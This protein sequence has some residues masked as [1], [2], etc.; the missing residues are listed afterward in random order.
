MFAPLKAYEVC[1]SCKR[2]SLNFEQGSSLWVYDDTIKPLIFQFKYKE[3]THLYDW[4]SDQMIKRMAELDLPFEF[5]FLVP[6][7]MHKKRQNHRGYDPVKGLCRSFSK[8]TKIPLFNGLNRSVNTP[9]LHKLDAN[10]REDVLKDVFSI[11]NHN[12]L[13]KNKTI[14][15]IDDIY[16]TGSTVNACA[17]VLKNQGVT[18][19]YV[20]TLCVGE[21]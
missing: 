20:L 18:Y 16:T 13:I 4:L 14:L 3:Q 1:D 8:K 2:L 19:I 10:T 21:I 15:L 12:H 17:K 7:P 11:S 6:V 9:P 5:D